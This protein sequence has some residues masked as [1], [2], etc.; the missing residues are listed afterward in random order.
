[1]TLVEHC[2]LYIWVHCASV[3]CCILMPMKTEKDCL[4]N[5]IIALIWRWAQES[6]LTVGDMLLAIHEATARF[7]TEK[8]DNNE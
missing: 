1:M 4:R 8:S 6:D 2:I 3:S 7:L 5:E